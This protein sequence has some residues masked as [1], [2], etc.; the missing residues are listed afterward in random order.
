MAVNLIIL[1]VTV[2]MAAFLGVWIC[3]PRLREWMEM[4][5]HRFLEQQRQFPEVHRKPDA[6]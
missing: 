1:A 6:P 4:P 3:I 5:K 2:L